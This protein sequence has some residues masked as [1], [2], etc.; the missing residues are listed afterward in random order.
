[1]GFVKEWIELVVQCISTL[2][3]SSKRFTSIPLKPSR[4]IRQGDPLSPY[5]FIL[6]SEVLTNALNQSE[7]KGLISGFPITKGSLSVNHLFF[8][9]DSLVFCKAQL[10]EWNRLHNIISLYESTSGQRL[11]LEKS[12]IFFSKNTR[13]EI[14]NSILSTA[15]IKASGPFERYLGLPSYIGKSKSRA[16][17]PILD[18][19]KVQMSNWKTNLLSPASKEVL[20]KSVIQ[21]IPTYCMGIFLIPKGILRN[22][23]KL[24]QSFW[25][26]IKKNQNSKM[27]WLNWKGLGKGKQVGGLGFRDFE[28]F[29]KA[30]LAKQGWRIITNTQSLASRVLKAKYF[31][32]TDFFSD[33]WLS[34]PTSYKSQSPPKVLSPEATVNSLIDQDSYSWNLHLVQNVF[35]P[36]EAAII[37][38][39]HVSPCNINDKQVLKLVSTSITDLEE[40]ER[41]QQKTSSQI[42]RT[43]RWC[44]P[45]NNFYKLNWDAAIDKAKCRVGIGVS[46]RDRLGLVTAT[47][48]SPC[49]SFPDPL[50]GEALAALRTVQFGIELGLKYIIFEGD[51]KQVVH[52]INGAAEDWSTVG[53]IYQDIKK[54]L[55]TYLSWSVCHVPRQANTVAHCLAK[56]SLDLSEDSIHVEDYPQYI[57]SYL[58]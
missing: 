28:D 2:L 35:T 10:Q 19:I 49:N 34:I 23:N 52:G 55:G 44:K 48:I 21:S 4:G 46:I 47:L 57:H 12:S 39:I 7:Q 36:E 30:L 15:G 22:I 18:R 31:P 3:Y 25:W 38:R 27:H 1:M 13:Q 8:S 17:F 20:L 56:S 14:Q 51:S 50:L 24:M 6:C 9:D 29:N 5:M 43:A 33:R 11:N 40:L 16:F 58:I 32:S 54:L 26:G 45:P 42:Q 53:L 41:N 37:S